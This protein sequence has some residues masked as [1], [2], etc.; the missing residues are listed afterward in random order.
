M[1]AALV[2]GTSPFGGESSSLSLP[3]ILGRVAQLGEQM[4]CKHKVAGSSPA[5]STT[6]GGVAQLVERK[7][8]ELRVGGSSPSLPTISVTWQ[9]G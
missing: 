5:V 1:A 6:S 8:E 3:T 9:S 7:P 2:L 4:L